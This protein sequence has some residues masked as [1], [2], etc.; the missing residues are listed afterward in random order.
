[1]YT[2]HR[3][4]MWFTPVHMILF[5]NLLIVFLKLVRKLS[6]LK[7]YW[8]LFLKLYLLMAKDLGIF[9]A[10]NSPVNNQLNYNAP[11]LTEKWLLFIFVSFHGMNVLS[12]CVSYYHYV[13]CFIFIFIFF[14]QSRW[15]Y[16]KLSLL[17]HHSLQIFVDFISSAIYHS[18]R[19]STCTSSGPAVHYLIFWLAAVYLFYCF[20]GSKKYERSRKKRLGAGWRLFLSLPDLSHA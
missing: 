4:S 16:L 3:L 2:V 9:H 8:R 20:R 6:L 14:P 1:M 7:P 17:W 19:Q 18:V 5:I 11:E 12:C 10:N 15:W 13:L